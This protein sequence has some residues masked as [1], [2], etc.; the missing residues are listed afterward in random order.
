MNANKGTRVWVD[1]IQG[2]VVAEDPDKGE[3]L[4][5]RF[6]RRVVLVERAVVAF[7]AKQLIRD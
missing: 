6:G 4:R 3:V 7:D 1:G 5:V 2:S